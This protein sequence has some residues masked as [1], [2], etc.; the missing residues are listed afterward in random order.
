[1]ES[2]VGE[3]EWS[4][5]IR[6]SIA[7]VAGHN[8]TVLITGPSGTG[9]ELIAR[10]IHRH[11]VRHGE[12]FVPV[13]CAA[14]PTSLA[15]SQL[16]GHVKGAFTGAEYS[17][18]GF[19]RAATDGTIFIDEIGELDYRL[20]A[21]LLRVIQER[22]VVPVGSHECVPVN[23]RIVVATN[24]DLTEAVR[25]G[26]FRLD[27]F[28]R[29]NVVPLYTQPLC[30]RKEDIPVLANHFLSKLSVD[31]GLP[32]KRLAGAAMTV[33]QQ[34]DWPGN[35][36]QL[37]NVLERA[38][39][40]SEGDQISRQLIARFLGDGEI[41][42]PSTGFIADPD[43]VET[44]G[45]WPTL[46]Q[47]ERDLIQRTLEHTGFQRSATARMLQ[48]DYRRLVRLIQKHSL[49]LPPPRAGKRSRS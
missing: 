32:H 37:E 5:G 39:G 11:S 49:E 18:V 40:F 6:K 31:A 10:A 23:V 12:P 19:F 42:A 8:S 25:T 4:C 3:S 13:D 38:V 20:Q 28:Y 36:R 16:F 48:I 14:I 26:G 33:L 41:A 43:D 21:Q 15:A 29:L 22:T 30:D 46:E 1:M 35:V 7:Q 47:S 34:F 9:K 45:E 27:L 44:E 17:S 24:R 2:I